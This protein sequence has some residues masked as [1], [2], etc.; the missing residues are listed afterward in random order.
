VEY[1]ENWRSVRNYLSGQDVQINYQEADNTKLESYMLRVNISNFYELQ[2]Y[3]EAFN[4]QVLTIEMSWI[5][6]DNNTGQVIYDNFTLSL[7]GAVDACREEVP[8]LG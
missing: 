2:N 8:V 4:E 1:V 7:S 5:T 3:M 6:R